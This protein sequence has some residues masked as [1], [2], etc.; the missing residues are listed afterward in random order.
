MEVEWEE[1]SAVVTG[2]VRASISPLASEGLD[3]AFG[4]AV[5]LGAIGSCEEVADAQ[6]VAGSGEEL[7]T[8]SRAA[9]GKDALDVDAVSLVEGDGLME[10]GQ[11]AGSFFIWENGG[12]SQ[13]GMIVDGDVEGLDA[14]AWIAVGTIAGGPDA[15]L[16]ET[17]KLFNIKVK[18]LAGSGAFVTQNRRLG[19]IEGGQ[20][21]ETVPFED[22]GKGSF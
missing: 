22:T 3:E 9:I 21:I 17:A 8:I 7:G 19:R 18:E 2:V 14:G 10:G 13:A 5:G 15:G 11:D 4:L 20:A 1:G 6:L 12:E 16:E